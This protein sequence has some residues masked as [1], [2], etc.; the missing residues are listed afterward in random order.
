MLNITRKIQWL[1]L[2]MT[3]VFSFRNPNNS[4]QYHC[5]KPTCWSNKPQLRW[6]THQ[7]D[8]FRFWSTFHVSSS[9]LKFQ[10]F[11]YIHSPNVQTYRKPYQSIYPLV[12]INKKRWNITMLLL[13]KATISMAIFNSK[14]LNY[15]SVN[16]RPD[17]IPPHPVR[18]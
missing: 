6:S 8:V 9:S 15:Q 17:V 14:L 13:G 7:I 4:L 1:M 3:Y 12:N 2:I 10:M 5:L 16:P 11:I 18:V